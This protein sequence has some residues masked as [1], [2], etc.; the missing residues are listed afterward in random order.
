MTITGDPRSDLFTPLPLELTHCNDGDQDATTIVN[1]LKAAGGFDSTGLGVVFIKAGS[2]PPTCYQLA[3]VLGTPGF[4]NPNLLQREF[5]LTNQIEQ[6]VDKI[7]LTSQTQSTR[8]SFSL[9]LTQAGPLQEYLNTIAN[10]PPAGKVIYFLQ[11]ASD[12]NYIFQSYGPYQLCHSSCDGCTGSAANQ[13]LACQGFSSVQGSMVDPSLEGRCLC[14]SGGLNDAGTACDVTCG[15]NCA[16]C[17]SASPTECFTCSNP[18][19]TIT[20]DA[21]G[22]GECVSGLGSISCHSDCH[23]CLGT[24]SDQCLICKDSKSIVQKL[25]GSDAGTCLSCADPERSQLPG[26]KGRVVA[27]ELSAVGITTP[28]TTGSMNLNNFESAQVPIRVP[29]LG[30]HIIRLAP[31]EAIMK[32][33]AALGSRFVFTELM[34]VSVTG[35]SSPADFTFAGAVNDQEKT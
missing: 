9:D 30:K 21:N 22:M 13:C 29:N 35:Y 18:A 10:V 25:P 33:I 17:N 3:A 34:R 28:T 1:A 24:G 31:P 12:L 20:R 19:H 4:T 27:I 8:N 14:S 15:G 32:R 7:E 5:L 2:S 11:G 23:S 26:C 6:N 16:S